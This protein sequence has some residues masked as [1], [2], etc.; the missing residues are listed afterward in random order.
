MAVSQITHPLQQ[1]QAPAAREGG[2]RQKSVDDVRMS[3]PPD[4][5]AGKRVTVMGLGHFGG[6]IAVVKYLVSQGAIVTV[7]GGETWSSWYNQP[8]AQLY[9]VAADFRF[10]YWVTGAQQDSG[11]VTVRTR[12]PYAEI[13]NRDWS[14]LCAGG[15]AGYTAPDPLHP[16][17]LHVAAPRSIRH[18]RNRHCGKRDSANLAPRRRSILGRADEGRPRAVRR[19]TR[20]IASPHSEGAHVKDLERGNVPPY[21]GG[22]TGR[23]LSSC[24]QSRR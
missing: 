8:T 13:S 5:F 7:N 22:L 1:V 2:E 16:E 9:H 20:N 14:P 12:S 19:Q 6:Q 10:P 23:L 17:I 4:Y 18:I 15:E 21:P 3:F 11:A 24:F